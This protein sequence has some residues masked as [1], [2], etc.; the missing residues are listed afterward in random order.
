MNSPT[1]EFNK[2][3]DGGKSPKTYNLWIWINFVCW[4][5]TYGVLV[6]QWAVDFTTMIWMY[7]SFVVLL[8]IWLPIHCVLIFKK[9]QS[10]CFASSRQKSWIQRT[11]D[12]V[13]EVFAEW[14]E[15]GILDTAQ[16]VTVR[17][18]RKRTAECLHLLIKPVPDVEMVNPTTKPTTNPT[19]KSAVVVEPLQVDVGRTEEEEVP[20]SL[21]W[22]KVSG[23]NGEESYYWNTETNETTFER[24]CL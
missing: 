6:Y 11:D 19:T 4:G 22:E 20:L 7:M 12:V 1:S 9:Q 10:L 16:F 14:M 24:P 3:S 15:R 8:L 2:P 13:K 17:V 23:T 21:N 5:A 18:S